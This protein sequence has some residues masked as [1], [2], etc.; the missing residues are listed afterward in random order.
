MNE[1]S[2]INFVKVIQENIETLGEMIETKQHST[3]NEVETPLGI[4][5]SLIE[6][7]LHDHLALKNIAIFGFRTIWRK[8]KKGSYELVQRNAQTVNRCIS[9]NVYNNVTQDET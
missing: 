3:Y 4:D 6:A 9:T 5:K 7:I 8:L 1:A 2:M